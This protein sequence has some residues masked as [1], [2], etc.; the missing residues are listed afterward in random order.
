MA[1][2]VYDM[3]ICAG[4][5]QLAKL[6][7]SCVLLATFISDTHILIHCKQDGINIEIINI[8]LL[9]LEH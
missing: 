1:H 2:P 9:F 5:S 7:N 6:N 3:S 4:W 8:L